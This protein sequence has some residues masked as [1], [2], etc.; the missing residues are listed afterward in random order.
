M[1]YSIAP[2][3]QNHVPMV[4]W[5]SASYARNFKLDTTCLKTR[6]RQPASHDHV[7]HSVLG[8]LDVQTGLYERPFDLAADCRS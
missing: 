1:P 4:M 6:A 2:K 5:F 7:F 3:E 8:L